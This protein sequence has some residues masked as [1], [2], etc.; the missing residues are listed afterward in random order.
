MTRACCRRCRIR[1]DAALS[2]MLTMCPRCG[3]PLSQRVHGEDIVGLALYDPATAD[4]AQA[5][6]EAAFGVHPDTA[7]ESWRLGVALGIYERGGVG[8]PDDTDL[9]DDRLA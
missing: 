9:D 2:D 5:G 1:F 8:E 7:E 6:A 3:R 4:A